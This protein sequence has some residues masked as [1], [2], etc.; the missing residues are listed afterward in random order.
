MPDSTGNLFA[1]L[2]IA[3]ILDDALFFSEALLLFSHET[4]DDVDA[5]LAMAAREIGIEDAYRYLYPDALDLSTSMSTLSLHSEQRSSMSIHSRETQS[6]GLT[7]QPSRSSRDNPSIPGPSPVLPSAPPFLRAFGSLDA[8]HDANARL[9]SPIRHCHSTSTSSGPY[10]SLG[11]FPVPKP[12]GRKHKRASMFS[13][14]TK[15]PR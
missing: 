13:F 9:S 11:L 8:N 12:S 14:F 15:D 6:T 3:P 2:T 4:E 7:S 1:D 5:Q 10:P